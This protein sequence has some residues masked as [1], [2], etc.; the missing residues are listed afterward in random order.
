[1]LPFISRFFECLI[2]E[3]RNDIKKRSVTSH[4]AFTVHVTNPSHPSIN[5]YN[6]NLSMSLGHLTQA[7]SQYPTLPKGARSISSESVKKLRPSSN[8]IHIH[9]FSTQHMHRNTVK[10]LPAISLNAAFSKNGCIPT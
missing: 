8:H 9:L 5:S 6:H 10:H 2:S 7:A 1:M 3:S 4:E